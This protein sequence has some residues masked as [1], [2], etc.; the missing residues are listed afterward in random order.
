MK[1][2]NLNASQGADGGKIV[3]VQIHGVIDGGWLDDSSTSTAEIANALA[4][5]QDAKKVNTHINSVGGSLFGGV[6]LFNVLQALHEK[7]VEV[8]S[9]VDG[10]AASAASLIAMAG[11]T[12]MGQGAMLMIHNP[13]AIAM[14]DAAD[15]RRTAAVL[16]KARDS[17]LAIYKAKT[18]KDSTTLKAMLDAE[19]WLGADQAMRQGFADE[20]AGDAADAPVVED[21]GENVIFNSAAFPRASLHPQI[22]AMAAPRTPPAPVNSTPRGGGKPQEI[23]MEVTREVL[24]AKFPDLLAAL[25]AEGK[26]AGVEEG[27]TAGHAAGVA[28]ERARLQAIDDLGLK[29]CDELVV[30]AKYG[31]K[32]LEARDLAVAVLKA[33]KVA[34]VDMLEAR[35]IES[36]KAA[37]VRQ[38]TPEK[39]T[40]AA[41]KEAAKEIAEYANRRRGGNK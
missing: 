41:E 32:P 31:E 29:G 19:T 21:E 27:K 9:Y 35:R 20:I 16:D 3:D 30:A 6:A 22:L 4:E 5:H 26:G 18:G 11:K 40:E 34:A 38:S 8:T 28:A 1:I 36:E 37:T 13:M 17:L 2:W 23:D 12:V 33:G 24:A 25:I 7:G 10:L 14:G 15:L 39:P